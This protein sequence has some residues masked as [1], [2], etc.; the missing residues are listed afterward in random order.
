[1]FISPECKAILDAAPKIYLAYSGG[2]DSHSLLHVCA[3]KK[4]W[5][6]KLTAVYVDH[7]LQAQ[8]KTWGQHC[9]QQAELLQVKFLALS[10][11]AQAA[12]GVSPEAAARDA[13]YAALKPLLHVNE[14][15]LVAQHREDQLETVLLQL[16]RG[17]G[18]Q[19]LA[20]MPSS[21]QFGKGLMLRPWLQISQA[22]IKVYA[23]QQQ[24]I[25]V[26]DP[27]NNW[28]DFDRNFLR[29]QVIPIIK[30][31]WQAVDKTVARS[32]H[33][34]ATAQTILTAVSAELFATVWNAS[35][36]T[37]CISKLKLFKPEQQVLVIRYWFSQQQLKMP[38]TVC[39]HKLFTEVINAQPQANPQLQLS[40][41]VLR[42]YQNKLYC[43]ATKK[44]LDLA[45]CVDWNPATN[46]FQLT[47]NSYLTYV[48]SVTGII[49]TQWHNSQVTV[50][51]RVG[52]EKILLSG[53][54][55][56]HSLKK[57]FQEA[58]IPP[59]ERA[60]IPLIYFNE[61]LVA[62]ADLWIHAD[63][64]GTESETCYQLIWHQ[65]QA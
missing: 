39:L 8:A 41:H 62:V 10:V 12:T 46:I 1:M 2:L 52:G 11:N 53:R 21:I 58:K 43:L 38:S 36:N 48:P 13:R 34:C 5:R 24:L 50:R 20:A 49:A 56:Q 44:F 29:K 3:A 64:L 40:A 57:L 16:F 54:K 37:V 9:Q 30:Q 7:G 18:V 19:G 31:R 42:R 32:A 65:N 14:V 47:T 51:K 26:E 35:D 17:A 61:N 45:A 23:Q 25:W 28:L 15:L 55:G 22:E 4:S 27:S 59:W 33:H 63:F 6:M 60:Q